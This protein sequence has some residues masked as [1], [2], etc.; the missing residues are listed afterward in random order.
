M[1]S[2]FLAFFF[3]YALNI[4]ATG[5]IKVMFNDSTHHLPEKIDG[6]V[7]ASKADLGSKGAFALNI[8]V[9]DAYNEQLT[10][11]ETG[12]MMNMLATGK[13]ALT[14]YV[15]NSMEVKAIVLTQI[16]KEV[17]VEKSGSDVNGNSK[18]A[19]KLI[20]KGEPFPAIEWTDI[21]GQ[22][23]MQQELLGKIVVINCW[24]IACKPCIAEMPGLNKLVEKY[25]PSGVVFL[26]PA[27][28]NKEALEKFLSQTSFLYS[29][30]PNAAGIMDSLGVKG[31]PTHI[32]LDRTGKVS[33]VSSG[34][35]ENTLQ[36][37]DGLIGQLLLDS[38][39]G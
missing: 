33:Y 21:H 38:Q 16:K 23:F 4:M 18:P 1:K 35:G 32:V 14:A 3:L 10:K 7:K 9:V 17:K 31:Y 22:K 20:G 6:Y 39:N 11:I 12:E 34:L 8:M 2:I 13:Y 37:I 26:A 15:D 29:A 24:F 28:D 5:Q 27:L 36:E 30:I 25:K 19:E